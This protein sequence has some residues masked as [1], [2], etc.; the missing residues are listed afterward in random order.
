VFAVEVAGDEEIMAFLDPEL[1]EPFA[2]PVPLP[3]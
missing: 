3:V 2:L 1:L